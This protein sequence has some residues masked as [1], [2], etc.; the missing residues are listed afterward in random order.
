[1]ICTL[2]VKT[3][4]L[5]IY[6]CFKAI[7]SLYLTWF[8]FSTDEFLLSP[9]TNCSERASLLGINAIATKFFTLSVPRGFIHWVNLKDTVIPISM[10]SVAC[11]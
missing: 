4:D 8:D 9:A 7:I 11:I 1:M 6:K 5:S 10:A 3:T 2:I